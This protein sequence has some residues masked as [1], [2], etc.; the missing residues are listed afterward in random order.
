MEDV[1]L[2]CSRCFEEFRADPSADPANPL[3]ETC[4]DCLSRLPVEISFVPPYTCSEAY[5]FEEVRRL[6][7]ELLLA[8][9]R[10]AYLCMLEPDSAGGSEAGAE[11]RVEN[12]N[13]LASAGNELGRRGFSLFQIKRLLGQVH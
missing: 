13:N 1:W 8:R 3:E 5:R 4:P 7:D 10:D 12:S 9:F 2:R 6:P 11:A